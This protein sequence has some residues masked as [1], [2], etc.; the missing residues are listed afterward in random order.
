MAVNTSPRRSFFAVQ[1]AW[2]Q[3]SAASWSKSAC[4]GG[5]GLGRSLGYTAQALVE[6]DLVDEHPVPAGQDHSHFGVCSSRSRAE[7]EKS[8]RS[9][10]SPVW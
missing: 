1:S 6:A 5:S 9:T 8:G 10:S 3:K 4:V 2:Y 7:S